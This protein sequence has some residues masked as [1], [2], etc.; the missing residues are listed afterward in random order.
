[1]NIFRLP[2]RLTLKQFVDI[3]TLKT[4]IHAESVVQEYMDRTHQF[5]MERID[6]GEQIYGVNTG[7]GPLVD[8]TVQKENM[9]RLQQDLL[10]QLSC[11]TG[12]AIPAVLARGTMVL[13]AN[14]I[15]KGHSAARYDVLNQLLKFI[16]SGA[17]P[18]IQ[19]YG[20]VGAS[21]DLIPLTRMAR[22]LSGLDKLRMPDGKVVDNSVQTL[23]FIGVDAVDLQP[24]EGLALVNGTSYS[25]AVT[26]FCLHTAKRILEG[27]VIP[28]GLTLMLLMDDSLQHL[29]ADAYSVKPHQTAVDICKQFNSWLDP[30]NPEKSHGLPQPPYS[31]R[32]IVLWL[33]GTQE[34]FQQAE[35]IIQIEMNSVDDNPLFFPET[36][37]IL[38]AANFQGSYVGKA[39]DDLSQG[40]VKV[41]NLMERQINRLFHDKLNGNLP[42]FLAPEPVGLHSGLQ[43][44]QLLATSLLSDIRT[45]A[46]A[47]STQTFPTNADNQDIVSMSAN[48]A[49]NALEIT[50][51]T[52]IITAVFECSLARALQLLSDTIPLTDSLK[53]WWNENERSALLKNNFAAGNLS[54]IVDGRVKK[55]VPWDA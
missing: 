53:R 18:V 30:I 2:E 9:N 47:H 45:K 3:A 40:L 16:N 12:P 29:S 17:T 42:A 8:K 15:S 7:F 32:S 36:D 27:Y 41:S 33:G 24:K 22:T 51:K 23:K 20:S 13:R 48:A 52:A 46:V 49:L 25:C 54:E 4:H 43:G 26:A 28:L 19:A 11:N 1:M 37:K 10:Q 6:E 5:L 38:H 34:H 50:R 55:M 21:G 44:F 39:A 31:A 14:A 35:K